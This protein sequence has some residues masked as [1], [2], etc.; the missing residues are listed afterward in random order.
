MQTARFGGP[1]CFGLCHEHA[2][3]LPLWGRCPSGGEAKRGRVRGRSVVDALTP[4][5]AR[6]SLSLPRDPPS[7]TRGEGSEFVAPFNE[8]ATARCCCSDMPQKMTYPR[9]SNRNYLVGSLAHRG[10]L[11]PRL[12]NSAAG[13]TGIH[14]ITKNLNL[15]TACDLVQARETPENFI[16]FRSLK[17][18]YSCLR[19]GLLND[20][21]AFSFV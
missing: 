16:T 7:P 5:P 9:P 11:T 19:L 10:R 4:H 1:F 17:P 2:S 21:H 8:P 14:G 18:S 20:C 13:V 6:A 3:P 12:R 15:T